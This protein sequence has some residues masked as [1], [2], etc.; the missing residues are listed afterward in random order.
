M[1]TDPG[2]YDTWIDGRVERVAP[3]G[4]AQRGQ[5]IDITTRG[6]GRRWS[7]QFRV[8]AVDPERH[9]FELDVE[10]PL[11]LKM[12]ERMTAVALDAGHTRL[13]FG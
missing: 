5:I 13:A 2:L 12:H 1:M 9:V 7:V 11:G 3:P 10:L 8:L 4:R 6:F